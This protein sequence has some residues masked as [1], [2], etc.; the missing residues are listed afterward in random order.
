MLLLEG[1]TNLASCWA[2][3]REPLQSA[4]PQKRSLK[5]ARITWPL[6]GGALMNSATLGEMQEF[7][8]FVLSFYQPLKA[9]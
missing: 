9:E 8:T 6:E 7:S 2:A 1:E 5:G 3:A 4:F